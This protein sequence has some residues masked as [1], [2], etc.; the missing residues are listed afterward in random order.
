L[1]ISASAISLSIEFYDSSGVFFGLSPAREFSFSSIVYWLL[2]AASALACSY[3]SD[4]LRLRLVKAIAA[5]SSASLR[6]L[7]ISASLSAGV[8]L[9]YLL[10]F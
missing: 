5:Y 10:S 4:L 2:R 9:A 8:R 1:V 3:S 6:S 7:F